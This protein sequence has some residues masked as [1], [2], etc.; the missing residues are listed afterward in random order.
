MAD[1]TVQDIDLS[2]LNPSYAAADAAGDRFQPGTTNPVLV[3]VKNGDAVSHTMTLVDARSKAPEAA[4]SFDP[5]VEIEI[6][7]GE[8][9]IVEVNHRFVD[10]DGWADIEY[11]AV[12]SVTIAVFRH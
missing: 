11:D 7:A 10:S 12:A 2:G 6:P 9:R 4:V 3:H 1:L 8:E 5:N